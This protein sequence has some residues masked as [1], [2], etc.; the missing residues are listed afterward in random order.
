MNELGERSHALEALI[1]SIGPSLVAF[2]GGVDSSLLAYV[3]HR[4]L[5]DEMLAILADGASLSSRERQAAMEF[6][7]R[8]DIP[9]KVVTTKEME[10]SGYVQNEGHRC[11][12]CK[13][14]LFERLEELQQTIG[15]VSESQDSEI[16]SVIY[17]VNQDDLGD[18]RPGLKA[19]REA[20]VISPY[21][22]LEMGKQEIRS[23]AT[24]Y[25]LSLA[26][27][28]AMPCLASRIPHGEVVNQEK[29]SQVEKAEDFLYGLGV[30]ECRVRHHGSVA[31]IEI[32]SKDMPWLLEHSKSVHERFLDFGF[33]FVSMDL[34]GFR[35]GS[36]N[37]VLDLNRV[38]Q[39]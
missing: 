14:A 4:V 30:S 1:K 27:K 29:L 37:E 2:S 6:A 17:G 20:E 32:P 28:P 35:S 38:S 8:Y 36:L 18:Y 7:K 16:W 15:L 25:G 19:A 31:R 26:A 5:G 13:Q 9:L 24:Y 12:Y 3:A 34:K 10:K 21:L 33:K 11:Y 23:L 39:S 22:Q